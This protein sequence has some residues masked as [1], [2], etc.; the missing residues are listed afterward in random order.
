[1]LCRE[2]LS[3]FPCSK[4]KGAALDLRYPSDPS[5][6]T[7]CQTL[8]EVKQAARAEN[9]AIIADGTCL[10]VNWVNVTKGRYSEITVLV[11]V[12]NCSSSESPR[13]EDLL[14]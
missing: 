3:G 10:G 8:R 12:N 5:C 9:T 2:P 6:G 7:D 14:I 11:T 1:M 4:M 13:E